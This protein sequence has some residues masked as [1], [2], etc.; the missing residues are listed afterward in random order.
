MRS[1]ANEWV[2]RN[3][4]TTEDQQR[5]DAQLLKLHP[6]VLETARIL[7]SVRVRLRRERA[8]AEKGPE[9]GGLLGALA[10]WPPTERC[11]AP[12]AATFSV[13]E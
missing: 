12:R 10:G 1:R 7:A 5:A 3:R 9:I 13:L 4:G 11:S 6:D 8:A 2:R